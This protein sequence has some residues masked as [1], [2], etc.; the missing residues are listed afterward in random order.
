MCSA[1]VDPVF[2]LDAMI[3]GADAVLVLGCHLGDC[4]YDKGNYAT[5]KR[6]ELLKKAIEKAGISPERLTL[7]WVSATE[8]EKF[9]QIV[10]DTVENIKKIG[11]LKK[12]V[13]VVP[14]ILM[15]DIKIGR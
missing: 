3:R 11:P 6:I 4:H 13:V 9:A 8:G 7:D 14:T 12:E 1:R 10:R 15:G 5:K 2:V